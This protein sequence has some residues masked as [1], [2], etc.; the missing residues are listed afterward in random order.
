MFH[1]VTVT[2]RFELYDL[3]SFTFSI[4]LRSSTLTVIFENCIALWSMRQFWISLFLELVDLPD[5]LI[6]DRL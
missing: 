4:L 3:P 1:F 2:F 6:A 5:I